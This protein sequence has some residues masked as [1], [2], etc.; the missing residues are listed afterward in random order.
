M[1][2]FI[3]YA[4]NNNHIKKYLIQHLKIGKKTWNKEWFI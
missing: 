3:S 4:V 1:M 2:S